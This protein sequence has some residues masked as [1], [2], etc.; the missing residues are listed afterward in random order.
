MRQPS[1]LMQRPCQHSCEPTDHDT[2]RASYGLIK[3]YTLKYIGIPITIYG[4]FLNSAGLGSLGKRHR[5]GNAADG[6]RL[7]LAARRSG[8]SHHLSRPPTTLEH[9]ALTYRTLASAGPWL[10][11][12]G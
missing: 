6:P 10:I 7:A 11:S 8:R 9:D 2:Q 12:Y 1:N 5:D 4:I 3:E